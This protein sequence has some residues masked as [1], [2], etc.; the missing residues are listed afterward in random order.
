MSV[1]GTTATTIAWLSGRFEPETGLAL[2]ATARSHAPMLSMFAHLTP[3]EAPIVW[4]AFAAGLVAGIAATY[5]VMRRRI[6]KQPS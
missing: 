2:P 6:A 4:L 3:L 1:S 5:A